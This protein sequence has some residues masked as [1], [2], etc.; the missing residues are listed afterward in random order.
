M[1]CHLIKDF[2]QVETIFCDATFNESSIS[3]EMQLIFEN[4]FKLRFIVSLVELT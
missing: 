3:L 1:P 2:Y 4:M